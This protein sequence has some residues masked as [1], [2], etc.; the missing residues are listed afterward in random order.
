M[1]LWQ[2][3]HAPSDGD[4]SHPAAVTAALRA[5]IAPV[6]GRASRRTDRC[7]RRIGSIGSAAQLSWSAQL[8]SSQ[9]ASARPGALPIIEC[10]A[11]QWSAVDRDR[12]RWSA[13]D[14][15]AAAIRRAVA[16]SAAVA[17]AMASSS[18]RCDPSTHAAQ[19]TAQQR[20]HRAHHTAAQSG[21]TSGGDCW[22]SSDQTEGIA[23]KPNNCQSS[24]SPIATFNAS[25][26]MPL[27]PHVL[28][29]DGHGDGLDPV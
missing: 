4:E 5:S 29:I 24:C 14:A 27:Q 23:C 18:R 8:S 10:S 12:L 11:M 21:I 28:I 9:L 16:L 25:F 1:A 20:Q 13:W 3:G 26:G 7:A 17:G 6:D 19:C 15:A 2:C 22:T